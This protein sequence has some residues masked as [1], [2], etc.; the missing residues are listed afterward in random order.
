[1]SRN[2]IGKV[3]VW[4]LINILDSNFLVFR[5]VDSVVSAERSRNNW[6]PRSCRRVGERRGTVYLRRRGRSW[7]VWRGSWSP[8]S[9]CNI[10]EA[11]E[12]FERVIYRVDGEESVVVALLFFRRRELRGWGDAAVVGDR[13]GGDSK[14]AAN[15]ET[16][17]NDVEEGV[18]HRF[19]RFC[20]FWSGEHEC[21][22]EGANR[23][24]SRRS[25]KDLHL[26]S[27]G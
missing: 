16:A 13:N 6:R 1:M 22:G 7:V 8:W 24:A 27:G 11:R 26:W 3:S 18:R 17:T 20:D 10:R 4:L 19:C 14:L 2:F 5:V 9:L 21:G 25:C 23:R 15:K 12:L